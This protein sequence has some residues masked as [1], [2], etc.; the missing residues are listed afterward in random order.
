ME[1]DKLPLKDIHLPDAIGWWPPAPGW[2]ILLIMIPL[3]IGLMVW[4]VRR[5]TRKSAAKEAKKLIIAIKGN[6]QWDNYQKLQ[7]LSELLRRTAISTHL[8]QECA[9]L[10][11]QQWLAF[12]DK[13]VKGSP[14][15]NGVGQ[16]LA[17]APYQKGLPSDQAITEL[18]LLCEN[19]LNAQRKR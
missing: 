19:W 16:L 15:S 11:G 7:A 5:I 17:D 13:S 10:T 1:P 9:G 12:L 18:T 14:F 6:S 8:R 2:W 3:V 4:L